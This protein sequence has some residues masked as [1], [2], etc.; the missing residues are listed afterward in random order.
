MEICEK[1]L[2]FGNKHKTFVNLK[3]YENLNL[4][5]LEAKIIEF[6]VVLNKNLSKLIDNNLCLLI[7]LTLFT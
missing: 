2:D 3:I 1:R 6:L 7:L 4:T 5:Y